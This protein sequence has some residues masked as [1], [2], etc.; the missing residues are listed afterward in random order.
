MSFALG[1]SAPG[2]PGARGLD[3]ELGDDAAE[4]AAAGAGA[5]AGAA[6][7]TLHLTILHRDS[8]ARVALPPSSSLLELYSAALAALAPLPAAPPRAALLSLRLLYGGRVLPAAPSQ[9]L[10]DARIVD[11]AALHAL[12]PGAGAGAERAATAAAAAAASDDDGGDAGGGLGAGGAARAQG[13]DR[14]SALGLDAAQVS[15]FRAQ[16]LPDVLATAEA[17]AP[18]GPGE[19]EAARLLRLEDAWM[20][21]QGPHSDFAVNIRP[22]LLSASAARMA[23]LMR[24]NG[25]AA[26]L[27]PLAAP[28]QP[29]PGW[30]GG[31]G[32]GAGA[33]AG[34]ANAAADGDDDDDEARAAVEWRAGGRVHAAADAAAERGTLLSFFSGVALGMALGWI[35]LLWVGQ[36]SWSVRFR[37]GLITGIALN[38]AYTIAFPGRLAPAAGAG[39]GAGGA[40][41]GVQPPP[42]PD[43]FVP[44]GPPP[45]GSIIG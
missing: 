19:S 39:G 17:E 13:F 15:M 14:L 34:N 3:P 22:L 6:S 41:G 8:R 35:M 21:A 31:A 9:T 30:R 24:A 16:F 28:L 12:F 4:L 33:G 37:A 43:P 26:P 10:H 1:A 7:G 25:G 2:A 42:H 29:P 11:G 40:G 45:G 5:G 20:R 32:A 27:L 18:A 23:A 44:V 36:S 38:I